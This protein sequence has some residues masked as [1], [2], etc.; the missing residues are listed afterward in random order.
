MDQIG[1]LI[2]K[3]TGEKKKATQLLK[4]LKQK[5]LVDSKSVLSNMVVTGNLYLLSASDIAS[6][7]EKMNF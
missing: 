4:S 3:T 1:G 2:P 7:T 6:V 5:E